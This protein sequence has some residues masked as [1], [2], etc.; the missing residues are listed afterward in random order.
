M[1]RAHLALAEEFVNTRAGKARQFG[2]IFNAD[3]NARLER[4]IVFGV[5]RQSPSSSIGIVPDGCGEIIS[6]GTYW[7]AKGG[8]DKFLIFFIVI[9]S[10][11]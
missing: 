6:R 5:Q 3:R 8:C 4:N 10:V 2:R 7:L 1:N 9:L 11:R